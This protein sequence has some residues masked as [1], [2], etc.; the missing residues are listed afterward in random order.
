MC[1]KITNY[2]LK[3]TQNSK[4]K[5]LNRINSQSRIWVTYNNICN[6]DH[7]YIHLSYILRLKLNKTNLKHNWHI[8]S[9]QHH[10]HNNIMLEHSIYSIRH[11]VQPPDSD[12]W[13]SHFSVQTRNNKSG[14]TKNDFYT[15]Y[16]LR[17]R[18][19]LSAKMEIKVINN[20]EDDWLRQIDSKILSPWQRETEIFLRYL[21]QLD[22][23]ILSPG[24]CESKIFLRYLCGYEFT[25]S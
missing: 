7:S 2:K 8:Q 15:T 9:R 12:V 1:T 6:L 22:S 17:K 21:R 19:Y 14:L 13:T 11:P 20:R 4:D 5:N 18:R 10:P 24:Q 3:T 25:S 16:Q 23:K